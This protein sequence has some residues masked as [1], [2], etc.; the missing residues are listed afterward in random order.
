[1]TGQPNE[2]SLLVMVDSVPTCVL[3]E[4]GPPDKVVPITFPQVGDHSGRES[5]LV[6][7]Y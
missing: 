1:M 3:F 6:F 4:E 5:C 7:V 2:R